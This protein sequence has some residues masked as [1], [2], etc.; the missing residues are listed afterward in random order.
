MDELRSDTKALYETAVDAQDRMSH[1]SGSQG[2]RSHA[3][4]HALK[5]PGLAFVP[6]TKLAKTTAAV[7][8][9]HSSLVPLRQECLSLRH[10][11]SYEAAVWQDKQ[12][13]L[14]EAQK[15]V[16]EDLDAITKTIPSLL[17]EVARLQE[18][19]QHLLLAQQDLVEQTEAWRTTEDSITGVIGRLHRKQ[20]SLIK[21]AGS[22]VD[23]LQATD[24]DDN[25]MAN[26]TQ[27]SSPAF[28]SGSS[29]TAGSMH[30]EPALD[31]YLECIGD[32]R[33]KHEQLDGLFIEYMEAQT[34]RGVR[35]DQEN[36]EDV[37]QYEAERDHLVAQKQAEIELADAVKAADY[38][39]WSCEEADISTFGCQQTHKEVLLAV[40]ASVTRSDEAHSL[41]SPSSLQLDI[42]V[43]TPS[44]VPLSSNLAAPQPGYL[45]LELDLHALAQAVLSTPLLLH[46]KEVAEERVHQW[47]EYSELHSDLLLDVERYDIE[48]PSSAALR[49]TPD[50]PLANPNAHLYG[51]PVV[52]HARSYTYGV[53][54]HQGAD[55]HPGP[56]SSKA[57][58]AS[59]SQIFPP[60][61]LKHLEAEVIQTSRSLLT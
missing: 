18:R 5:S 32:L 7:I 26:A 57:R 21:S 48:F 23:Q 55:R 3:L 28:T 39:L 54:I 16:M 60:A 41:R 30:L 52:R 34:R 58:R 37:L 27:P 4:P 35:A 46:H 53:T 6:G 8:R 59:E 42:P 2:R 20:D 38:A 47:M 19:H 36:G 33:D 9:L 14:L 17:P 50:L 13:W 51:R 10:Q 29:R 24:E 22:L 61:P 49:Q 44:D 31:I 25:Y 15:L 11:A 56:S 12:R 40:F 45:Q 1:S 43:I